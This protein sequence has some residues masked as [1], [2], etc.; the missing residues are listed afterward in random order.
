MSLQVWLP[1]NGD[2]HNQGL[3]NVT[4]TN[5]SAT[6][7]TSGK[8]GSCYNFNGSSNYLYS[9]YNFY[10]NQ[11]SVC[12]W[13]YTTSTSATQTICCDR[14]A[15]G[16]GFSIFLIGGKIRI[17]PGGNAIQ[18]TTNYTYPANTWFH[19]T[20]T[21]DGNK[22][23]YYI[24]GEL[25][26][27]SSRSISSTYWGTI[28]S[29]GASQTNGSGY[30]NYLNGK[31]NDIRIYDHCLSPKEVK[32][33]SKSLVLYYK[34]DNNNIENYNILTGTYYN[35]YG[36]GLAAASTARNID[37]KW[38][39]GSGGNGTFSVTEDS[40]C[41]I[42]SYSWNVLN[43]TS[44]NR[45]FQQGDQPYV[46]GQK[47][48]TSFYAKGNG[49]CLYRS[50]NS[51][52]G[53]QM[54][55]KTWTL[56]SDWKKYTYT[57]TASEEMETDSCTFHLGVT[58]SA[59][60]SICGMKMELGEKATPYCA[61]K[62]EVFDDTKVYDSSGYNKNGTIIGTTTVD[63]KTP[64][65]NIATQ[66]NNTSSSNHI[67]I[68]SGFIIQNDAL[69]VSFWIKGAKSTNQVFY[70]SPNVT[71]GSLNSLIYVCPTSA[72]GFTTTHFVNDNWNHIVAIR[73]ND[74]YQLY[75]NGQPETQNGANNYYL[76]NISTPWLLN[77]NYNNSYAANT[78]ISDFRIYCTAL[79]ADDI[80][81]LYNTSKL[82]DSQGNK[83]ARE[84]SSL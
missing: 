26:E 53:K 23:C 21:Y 45:D 17:D 58:G 34:L 15:V 48:T 69:T 4:V 5:N 51:T 84:V 33:I 39:A 67:E 59:N 30:G 29:I 55:Q 81:E 79:S 2:L 70:A 31:L 52:D 25:K 83:L 44:G 1:L 37:G 75:V 27:Y 54:F 6:I 73:T 57:F 40:T 41:P 13:V 80:K 65:N 77:R 78:T 76:H 63:I 82:V 28:T 18:W 71:I 72:A 47:Y 50:W 24:N 74:T 64:K 14:T 60:I 38:A 7:N 20:V 62:G 56:T 19:L 43:N 12:A 9:T 16:S 8:I 68:D 49:T 42:G 36:A 32:E 61:A 46:S 11:Y 66:M 22:V 35:S 3:S 10:N